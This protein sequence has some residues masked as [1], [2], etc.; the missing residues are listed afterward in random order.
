MSPNRFLNEPK[1]EPDDLD[2]PPLVYPRNYEDI[3]IGEQMSDRGFDLTKPHREVEKEVGYRFGQKVRV[4]NLD[5]DEG[6]QIRIG[7]VVGMIH[8]IVRK[9]ITVEV[10]W[11]YYAE[12]PRRGWQQLQFD[13]ETKRAYYD[14][15]I[16]QPSYDNYRLLD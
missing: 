5:R 9:L 8:E 6:D 11:F 15:G 16:T 2:L 10:V 14:D 7:T 4:Q 12:Y 1:K 13:V 3:T